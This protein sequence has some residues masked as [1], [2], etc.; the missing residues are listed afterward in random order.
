M[1][2]GTAVLSLFCAISLSHG[3]EGAISMPSIA[4][5]FIRFSQVEWNRH[6]VC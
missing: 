5:V 6:S 1:L 3:N 4:L 2:T